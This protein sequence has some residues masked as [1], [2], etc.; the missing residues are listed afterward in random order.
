MEV[1]RGRH[2]TFLFIV[3]KENWLFKNNTVAWDNKQIVAHSS[4]EATGSTDGYDTVI[5]YHLKDV[6]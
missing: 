3:T 4:A 5:W 2:V 6:P 1:S